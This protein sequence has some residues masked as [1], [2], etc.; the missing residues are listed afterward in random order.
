MLKSVKYVHFLRYYGS[1]QFFQPSLFVRDLDLI[2]KITVKDFEYF[3]D[4]SSISNERSDPIVTQNLFSLK[5][6]KWKRMRTTLTPAFTSSKMRQMFVLMNKAAENTTRFIVDRIEEQEK[7]EVEVEMKDFYSKYTND[8]IASCA[9]GIHCN[10]LLNED[11]DFF[12]MGKYFSSTFK[13]WRVFR[14]L[15][16]AFF[17]SLAGFLGISLFPA[18]V[19]EFFKKIVKDTISF[20]ERKQI[21]RPDLIHLLM[22]SRKGLLKADSSNLVQDVGFASKILEKEDCEYLEC[23]TDLTDDLITAQALVFFIAGF[24]TSSSI[25]SLLSYE[26]A[27]NPDIQRKLQTEID[28]YLKKT[29]GEWDYECILKM[30]YLDQVISETLRMYPPAF[31]LNR[32]CT[33]DYF[34]PAIKSGEKDLV[35]EKGCLVVIPTYGIHMS[36]E[37]FPDPD[38]FD[39][40]RFCDANKTKIIPG[41]YLPFGR[42][43]RNCIGKN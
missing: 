31:A 33:K 10:S 38:R 29:S 36:P 23:N 28:E 18:F 13:G 35:V 8:V 37:Y 14:A 7:I 42:G 41:T 26:L 27:R 22:Q 24:E 34:I 12:Q 5:G 1:Y 11:N 40:D 39:P 16:N 43:P 15:I 19:S 32:I 21:V 6:E 9:F 25:L 4:H 30:K 17:P 3:H 20:R 2:K